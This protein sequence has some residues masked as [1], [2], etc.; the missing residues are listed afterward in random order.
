M[1]TLKTLLPLFLLL[2][3]SVVMIFWLMPVAHPYGGILLPLDAAEIVQ[4]SRTILHEIGVAETGLKTD[5]E[6][7]TN[8]SLLRQAQKS[9]GIERSNLLIRDSISAYYWSVRW[10]KER[11]L[12]F[13]FGRS[14]Q[15]DKREQE[16]ADILRGD[17]GFQFN[18]RGNVLE[19]SR[20]V[21]DSAKLVSLSRDEAKT[22]AFAFLKKYTAIGKLLG[23]TS[24]VVSEKKIEQPFRT[25]YEFAWATFS[26]VLRDPVN[27]KVTIAGNI[28]SKFEAQ[29]GVPEQSMKNSS[30][31][32]I[33]VIVAL[34]Y[35]SS[36]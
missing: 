8:R 9:F 15:S 27:A 30:D 34:L 13:S 10:R 7:Q 23:D 11:Q 3:L 26:P 6:F 19:F 4:R 21:P 5:V 33:Q 18:T 22:F 32:I 35:S 36:A 17:I 14:E 25:D 29:P 28:V 2:A 31:T 1:Q 20:K 12:N 16:L 24:G